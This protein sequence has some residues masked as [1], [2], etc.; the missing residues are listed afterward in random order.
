MSTGVH[1]CDRGPCGQHTAL[2]HT[3]LASWFLAV[4]PPSLFQKVVSKGQA[5]LNV[6]CLLASCCMIP[7][8]SQCQRASCLPVQHRLLP[9][10]TSG[11]TVRKI[12]RARC[13]AAA[14]STYDAFSTVWR[15]RD[16]E[17][18]QFNVVNN[19]V[20]ASAHLAVAFAVLSFLW[21]ACSTKCCKCCAVQFPSSGCSL[22]LFVPLQAIASM[23]GLALAL[24]AAFCTGSGCTDVITD[25][26]HAN[27]CSEARVS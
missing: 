22:S 17:L 25:A 1:A 16:Y 19:A 14:P 5:L 11:H 23:V 9:S 13:S 4:S 27:M 26:A 12:A 21:L 3:A 18:D 20:Y 6:L 2:A 10:H 8:S 24:L 15:V 7:T